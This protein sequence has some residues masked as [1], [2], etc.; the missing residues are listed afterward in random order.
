MTLPASI[1]VNVR[2]SFPALVQG[3]AFITVA[4][5]NGIWSI[6]PNYQLLAQAPGITST[7]IL[8]VYDT[9]TGVWNYV[10]PWQIPGFGLYTLVTVAGTYPVQPADFMILLKKSPSGASTIQLPTSASR[11]GLPVM[12]KDLTGDANANNDTF[13]PATGETIDGFSDSVAAANGV[14]VI[15]VDYGFKKLYPL[16]SGGWYVAS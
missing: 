7:Q 15:D 11:N 9:A 2:V 13:V 10:H 1:R 3:S 14:A 8:A 12:V 5:A 16:V 6:S 4:K